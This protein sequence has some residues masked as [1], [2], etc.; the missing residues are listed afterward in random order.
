MRLNLSPL[1]S[2]TIRAASR[3]HL[4]FVARN[5]KRKLVNMAVYFLITFNGRGT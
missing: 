5:L 2:V 4:K 1:S 3:T